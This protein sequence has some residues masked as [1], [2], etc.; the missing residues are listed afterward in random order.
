[1]IDLGPPGPAGPDGRPPDWLDGATVLELAHLAESSRPVSH[2]ADRA[3]R[4]PSSD[5]T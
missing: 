4:T 1:M 5:A 2:L 3:A